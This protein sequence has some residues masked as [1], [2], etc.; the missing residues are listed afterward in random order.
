M[1]IFSGKLGCKL[2][3]FQHINL[4]GKTKEIQVRKYETM[5][6]MVE[7]IGPKLDQV[8]PITQEE[9]QPFLEAIFP[10]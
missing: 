3:P 9:L 6:R 8:V 10:N 7:N 1:I 4:L 5:K 2:R